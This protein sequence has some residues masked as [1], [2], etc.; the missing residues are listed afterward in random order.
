MLNFDFIINQ[1]KMM[2]RDRQYLIVHRKEKIS[3]FAKK[4]INDDSQSRI[5]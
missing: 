5:F 3:L 2:L 4:I 1:I